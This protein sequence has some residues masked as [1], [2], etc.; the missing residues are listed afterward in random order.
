MKANLR[1]I[2]YQNFFKIILR[3]LKLNYEQD[4]NVIVVSSTKWLEEQAKQLQITQNGVML[5][6]NQVVHQLNQ[7]EDQNGRINN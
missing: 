5:N 7:E 2:Y 1:E 4:I 6:N 3:V